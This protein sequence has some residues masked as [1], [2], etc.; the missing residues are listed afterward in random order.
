MLCGPVRKGGKINENINIQFTLFK[1]AQIEFVEEIGSVQ[2]DNCK[3]LPPPLPPK[4]KSQML[5]TSDF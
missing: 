4:E 1:V 5:N 2:N 3:P